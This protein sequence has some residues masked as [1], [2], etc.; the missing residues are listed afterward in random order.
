[1]PRLD[2]WLVREGYFSSRQA[3]KRAIKSGAVLVD[4]KQRK[5]SYSMNG[6]ESI[7]LLDEYADTP[8]GFRK[9]REIDQILDGSLSRAD[10]ALDI[11]SSAGGFLKYL[12]F[13]DTRVIIGLE[14][15][16]RFSE[17]LSIVTDQNPNISILFADAFTV[18]PLVLTPTQSLDLLLIDVTT[19]PNGT[20]ELVERFSCLLKSEGLLVVA[21]KAILGEEVQERISTRLRN[22]GY[23]ILNVMLLDSTRQEFHIAARRI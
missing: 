8:L 12:S 3:A 10:S 4:G 11:G 18:E 20:I 21:I 7:T 1:M 5:P 13:I 19:S 6:L 17:E 23:S 22:L 15:S 14:V 2:V 9:L 16:E